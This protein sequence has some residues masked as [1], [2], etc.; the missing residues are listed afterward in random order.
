MALYSTGKDTH[1]AKGRPEFQA[2]PQYSVVNHFM[3]RLESWGIYRYAPE[4]K[5]KGAL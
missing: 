5:G 3:I 4:V 1:L 2:L